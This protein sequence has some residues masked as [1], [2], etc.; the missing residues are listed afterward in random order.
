MA[1]SK[2]L[3]PYLERSSGAI[4]NSEKEELDKSHILLAALVTCY[5]VATHA[6]SNFDDLMSKAG[7]SISSDSI[8]KF[9]VHAHHVVSC[10]TK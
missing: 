6:Y 5:L 8:N 2:D 7:W 4:N 10:L 3:K 1:A 9:V